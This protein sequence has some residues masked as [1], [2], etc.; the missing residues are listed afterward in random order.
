MVSGLANYRIASFDC[1]AA[2]GIPIRHE[3]TLAESDRRRRRLAILLDPA[4][5]RRAD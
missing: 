3:R 2:A 1:F 4:V 5:V